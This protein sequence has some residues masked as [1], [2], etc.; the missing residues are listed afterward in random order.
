VSVFCLPLTTLGEQPPL[1]I[2]DWGVSYLLEIRILEINAK[3]DELQGYMKQKVE[4]MDGWDGKRCC[5]LHTVFGKWLDMGAWTPQCC[6]LPIPCWEEV[7]VDFI[8][9]EMAMVK[10]KRKE[11]TWLLWS[12][13]N[14]SSRSERKQRP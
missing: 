2:K 6:I 14:R 10:R 9:W 1:E 11:V 7:S 12:G 3:H 5:A 13:H 8:A 4:W